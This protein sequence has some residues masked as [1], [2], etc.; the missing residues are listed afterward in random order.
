MCENKHF[1]PPCRGFR[2][3]STTWS[4]S[5]FRMAL[6]QKQNQWRVSL[7][8]CPVC[9]GSSI[10][11]EPSLPAH[12]LRGHRGGAEALHAVVVDEARLLEGGQGLVDLLVCP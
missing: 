10:L 11:L 5:F 3:R 12:M 1:Q 4:Q 8:S 9:H 2:I 6:S 7:L